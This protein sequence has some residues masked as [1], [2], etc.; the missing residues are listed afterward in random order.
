MKEVTVIGVEN[1]ELKIA[2]SGDIDVGNADEFFATVETAYTAAKKPIVFECSE[3][4][5]IDSTTLGIFVKISKMAEADGNKV[6]L[7][8]LQAR[9]KKLFLIC[10]LGSKMEIV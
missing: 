6:R 5:F 4:S 7:Y 2:L 10:A 3:L 8:S 1:E 9:I